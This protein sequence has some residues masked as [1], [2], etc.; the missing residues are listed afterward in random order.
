[1][2]AHQASLLLP[3]PPDPVPPLQ[4]EPEIASYAD[5]EPVPPVRGGLRVPEFSLDPHLATA[6]F[7]L[8]GWHLICP[9]IERAATHA[10]ILR[11]KSRLL[12]HR[13]ALQ[14][15]RMAANPRMRTWRSDGIEGPALK[16]QLAN[17]IKAARERHVNALRT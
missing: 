12:S 1:M 8:A 5:F 3:D 4:C 7:D 17:L 6:H 10:R 15:S 14:D 2:T 11:S 16:R 13:R 9:E